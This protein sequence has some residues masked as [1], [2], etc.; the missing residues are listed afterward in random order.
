MTY[1]GT[2]GCAAAD[3]HLGNIAV[4][5]EQ[6]P[7]PGLGAFDESAQRFFNGRRNETAELRRLVLHA[8]L[9]V[10]FAASGLGKTSLLQAG[11]FPM[12]RRENFLPIYIRLDLRDRSAPL[13]DQVMLAFA[14][15]LTA[16][17]VDAPA[18]DPGESLWHYLHRARLELWSEQNQL[19]T[20]LFVFDQ[21]EE[22]FTLGAENPEAIAR[23]RIDLA[24]L[25]ENRMP[26]ALAGATAEHEASLADLQLDSQRYKVVLSF[27]EDFLP[28]MEGWK[29][30]IPSILRNRARL[31]PMS[32]EQAFEAVYKTASHLVDET[33]AR[34]IVRFVAAAQEE[35]TEGAAAGAENINELTVE[36]A[37]LSLVCHGLN[38][39][40]KAQGKPAFDEAFLSGNAQSIVLDYYRQAV[41][42]L[43]DQVQ[44]FIEN[45][46]ITERGFRK[47]CDVDDARTIH[48]VGDRDLRLLVDRRLLRIEPLRG[49]ERVELTHDLLTRVVR[50]NRD[51]RRLQEQ[52]VEKERRERELKRRRQQE[53]RNVGLVIAIALVA[54]LGLLAL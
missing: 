12:L 1:A 34:Q 43:P 53:V 52:K 5:D 44:I 45:E 30:D 35:E 3:T 23:L 2:A 18:L 22:V 46:L 38:E 51:Q 42:D 47:Q 8:P 41:G 16:H 20:P 24:D 27:R 15:Q 36:P 9:T 48:G 21:F 25:I 7:W 26:A 37:L 29:R 39:K 28:A 50:E 14:S 19:L 54:A 13:V 31:L 49:S 11:L 4:I 6:N 10:L 33:T 32:A 17:R 40:R